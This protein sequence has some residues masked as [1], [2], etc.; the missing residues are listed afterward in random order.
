MNAQTGE[1]HPVQ[2]HQ[3][4]LHRIASPWLPD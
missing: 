2:H 1:S 4:S 3:A